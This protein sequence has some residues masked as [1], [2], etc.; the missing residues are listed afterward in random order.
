MTR[1]IYYNVGRIFKIA[2]RDGIPTWQAA[3][4]M[5]EERIA[6]LGKLKLP[7]MGYTPPRFHGRVRGQ[8]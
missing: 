2:E 8:H 3:D 6:T 5:A 4:R 7:H 1:T